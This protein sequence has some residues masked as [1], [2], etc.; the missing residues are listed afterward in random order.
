M[1][2]GWQLT[3]IADW[4][5]GTPFTIFSGVDNSFSAIGEDRADL[6]VPKIQNA[7]PSWPL[8][9]SEHPGVVQYQ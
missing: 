5:T 4:Q 2:N 3:A 8:A 6:T 7:R 1:L 9:F